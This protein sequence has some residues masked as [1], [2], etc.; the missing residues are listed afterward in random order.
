MLRSLDGSQSI[1]QAG[2]LTLPL[3]PTPTI[4]PSV[5]YTD[6]VPLPTS[7]AM[8]LILSRT[9][10]EIGDNSAYFQTSIQCDGFRTM[11]NLPVEVIT[12]V[13]VTQTTITGVRSVLV[14]SVD[15]TIDM[16]SGLVT[17]TV[18]PLEDYTL[19]I[20]GTNNQF[21]SDDE[22]VTLIR[23]AA[24]KHTHNAETLQR[25]IDS[26]G[27]RQYLY[28]DATVDTIAPVEYH[29]VALLAAVEALE[30]ISSDIAYDIDVSTAEGTA[31][32]R[33]QRFRNVGQ[34][35]AVKQARYDD[36]CSKLGVGLGRIEVFTVRRV[37][38]TNGRLIPVWVNK[39]YDE[40]G[41]GANTPLRV[42]TPRNKD[43]TGEG[44]DQPDPRAYYSNGSGYG[45]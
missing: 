34:Q 22:L 27:F 16:R 31:L 10:L 39:E 8:A 11:F 21:F 41:L 28:S 12:T 3:L 29:L 25:F 15:F 30:I 38:R 43:V 23:S 37:S 19:T 20:S 32:P 44:F 2:N 26:N 6:P 42:L 14:P 7:P 13:N 4:N 33:S 18:P 17:T 45:Y 9:R 40:R 1:N 36:L 35:I 5:V 24:L